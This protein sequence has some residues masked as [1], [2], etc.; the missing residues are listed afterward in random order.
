MLSL[1]CIENTIMQITLCMAV[2]RPNTMPWRKVPGYV[3]GQLV[4]AW[5]GAIVVFA[6]YFHAID[7]VEGQKGR[8]T[9][10]TAGLF[11]TFAVRLVQ[12]PRNLSHFI[13]LA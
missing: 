5:L 2:F 7:I 3:I 11:G 9:L 12:Q 10:S 13:F 4:G 8:R 6:N 1:P